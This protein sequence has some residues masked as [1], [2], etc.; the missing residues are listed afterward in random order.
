MERAFVVRGRLSD[1]RHI[2]LDEPILDFQGRIELV[3][4]SPGAAPGR[5]ERDV[6]DLVASMPPGVRAKEDIDRDL[7]EERDSW[8][9]R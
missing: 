5:A 9:E 3:V 7:R 8:G 6:F 4:L 2:E 1:P